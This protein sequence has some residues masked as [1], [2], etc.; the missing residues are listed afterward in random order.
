MR[1]SL[2]ESLLHR[3]WRDH[4]RYVVA[5]P[6]LADNS[7]V[8]ILHPGTFNDH[9][10]GP[11]FLG[12]EIA[13][14]GIAIKGD[15]EIHQSTSDWHSHGHTGDEKYSS[16]IL[17]VVMDDDDI[18]SPTM[19]TLVLRDNLSF[20]EREFWGQLFEERYA[21]WPELP[22]FP[23]NLAV[24]MKLKRVFLRQVAELR[25]AALIARFQKPTIEA[26]DNEAYERVMDALGYSENRKPMAELAKILPRTLLERVRNSE[27]TQHLPIIFEALFFGAAGLIEQPKKEYTDDVN[28]YLLDLGAR[29]QSLQV[30][31]PIENVLTKGDWAFFR[32]R[33]V[34][35]PYRRV[36]LAASL[37]ARYFSRNDFSLSEDISF[38]E[39]D[40]WW[41]K[42]TSFKSALSEPHSLLGEERG[43]AIE[44]NVLI[45]ARIAAARIRSSSTGSLRSE[46]SVRQ[47]WAE[48]PSR[49]SAAYCRTI[50]QELLE[51][52][53]VRTTADEQG[54]LHLYR[55]YCSRLR[56]NECPVGKQLVEGGWKA[57]VA[58]L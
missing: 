28:E 52:E 13:L 1:S 44:I 38:D 11:D 22:C 37:A 50:E 33:P 3:I 57:P 47:Q 54:A 6:R 42:H 25:L 32:I 23:H 29:W 5:S 31:C 51:G 18:I 26:L 7:P 43:R 35:S 40:N 30:S 55:N 46:R 2:K 49:S 27:P 9:R 48:L 56:C 58:K 20:D 17:H 45:P 14:E 19:P 34:N 21:H 24:R 41:L 8:R 12:A 15:I 53:K 4:A 36:A 16:V 10:G 39:P